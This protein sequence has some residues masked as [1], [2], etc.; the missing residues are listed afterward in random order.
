MRGHAGTPCR[1]RGVGSAKTVRDIRPAT[2]TELEAPAAAMPP[3]YRL[4][5]LLAA[6]CAMRFGELAR[7]DDG[8]VVKDP[9]SHAGKRDVNIPRT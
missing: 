8:P 9:E 4:M 7:T 2:L 1:V 5:V 3:R 6:W